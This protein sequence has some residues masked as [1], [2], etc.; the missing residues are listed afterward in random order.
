MAMSLRNSIILFTLLFNCGLFAQVQDTTVFQLT[1]AQIN[2]YGSLQLPPVT[3]WKFKK[4]NDPSWAN[5]DLDERGW[6]LMDSLEIA[7]LSYDKNDRFEGWFRFRFRFDP[8]IEVPPQF[9]FSTNGAA[10]DIYLNGDLVA[11]F[12]DT[13]S[14][15]GS[16]MRNKGGFKYLP[17]Q[18][19]KEYLV[20]IHF[21]DWVGPISRSVSLIRVMGSQSFLY[22]A[23]DARRTRLDSQQKTYERDHLIMFTI[24]ALITL[25]FWLIFVLNSSEKYL[26][27]IA[28]LTTF[29]CLRPMVVV[30]SYL[31]SDVLFLNAEWTALL[32]ISGSLG[33]GGIAFTFPLVLAAIFLPS[34]PKWLKWQSFA[35][36]G[37]FFPIFVFFAG[38][39]DLIAQII[40]ILVTIA[41]IC[42]SIIILYKSW[43]SIKGAKWIVTT[44][45]FALMI[46]I[47]FGIV[48]QQVGVQLTNNQLNYLM[49]S[50]EL[51]FPV[52]LL[53]YVAF[54]IK[55]SRLAEQKKAREVIRVTAEKQELLTQQN[56]LLEKQV[57]ERTT[58]LQNSLQ[59]LKT[60]QSQ[61]IQSEK[62]ASLGE[63]T[64]GIAH[65]IQNPLNFVNNFSEVSN[66]LI[67]EMNEELEKGDIP[68]AMEISKD[69]KQ[70]LG[71]ILHHG[72]R[73][74]NIVKGML[75][76]SRSGSGKKELTDINML[77]DEYLRLAYHGLRA[78]DKSFNATMA[79][80]FDN[81][82]GKIAVISQDLG[83]V[84]LNLI[85][86]AF[87]A[88]Q[89]RK[90]EGAKGYEPTVSVLTKK[91]GNI[92][93]IRVKDN[94][95]GIPEAIKEKIFQPFFTTKPTGQGTGLGLSMSYDIVTKG[96][97]GNLK[98]ETEEGKG[99]TFCINLPVSK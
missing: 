55:E 57:K 35:V 92:V 82:I 91:T 56:V 25:L 88:V 4:G 66:E 61:L 8:D 94:G 31:S 14:Q 39:V 18:P 60:T 87:Y 76:H 30:L 11:S 20:A 84:I 74:D 38:S 9:L 69:I 5:P 80:D 51:F 93:E 43:R 23:T 6:V 15:S 96:H 97:G 86:N 53:I 19:G 89:E 50:S 29:I 44:G 75:Q 1:S 49:F 24:L 40:P 98:V 48:S 68:E 85:T 10:Q 64:A 45:L 81:S 90:K 32:I 16:Y 36:L 58:D 79:T 70:N 33:G 34:I 21:L 63:L 37:I 17:F 72:K 59:N 83:R 26:L 67:D 13:G 73:A 54:W 78:K 3:R 27:F 28:L 7:S 99:T 46:L 77:T 65:E 62:M 71:K 41:A 12:G 52:S 42:S 2:E 95:N 22:L 47:L